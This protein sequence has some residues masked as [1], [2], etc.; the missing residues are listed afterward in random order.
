[1]N[2][3]KDIVTAEQINSLIEE[4][5][6]SH[7]Y[8]YHYSDLE[9]IQ[10]IQNSKK[11]YVSSMLFSNDVSEHS[12]FG[13]ETYRYFQLCFSTGTTENLP[14]WFLYSGI[15]GRG[16]RIAL[17]KKSI[18]KWIDFENKYMRHDIGKAIDEQ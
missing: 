4:K 13:E 14:L 8:Y 7:T 17:R 18:R 12:K 16:A 5:S 2:N 9:G 11:I 15:N 10:G 1:M 3:F 6:Y